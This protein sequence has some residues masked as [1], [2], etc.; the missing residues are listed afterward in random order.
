MRF[1]KSYRMPNLDLIPRL[2]CGMGSK[3][4]TVSTV[5]D[6][7]QRPLQIHIYKSQLPTE[8]LLAGLQVVNLL[9]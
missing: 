3:S 8:Y 5:P 2:F 4:G 7:R 9:S 6:E 1:I